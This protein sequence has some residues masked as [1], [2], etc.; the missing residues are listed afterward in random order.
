MSLKRLTNK[1]LKIWVFFSRVMVNI[2]VIDRTKKS[3]VIVVWQTKNKFILSIFTAMCFTV[4][5]TMCQVVA[6]RRFKTV[7]NFQTISRKSGDGR[8]RRWSFTRCF[9]I[10]LWLRTL[11]EISSIT[12]IFGMTYSKHLCQSLRCHLLFFTR[13]STIH[14]KII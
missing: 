9:S 6:Y 3:T 7:E 14:S 13:L 10:R 5:K 12:I 4:S 1:N 8:L 2:V 11:E